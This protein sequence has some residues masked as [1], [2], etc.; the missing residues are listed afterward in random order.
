M[1]GAG[2]AGAG[3][4]GAGAAGVGVVGAGA[5]GVGVVGAGLAG[6]AGAAGAAS[7]AQAASIVDNTRTRTSPMLQSNVNF[8]FFNLDLQMIL[9]LLIII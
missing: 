6:A 2:A 3:V 8:L 4:V 7:W 1:V 5:A 9:S